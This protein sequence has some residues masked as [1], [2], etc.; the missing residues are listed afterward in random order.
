MDFELELIQK[1]E[2]NVS[3]ILRLLA[4]LIDA[5]EEEKAK[6]KQNIS[7]II[8][9]NPQLRSKKELIE[10]FI[11]GYLQDIS[12]ADL[13]DEAFEKYWDEQKDKAFTQI[14]EDEKLDERKIR[15]VIDTYIYDQRKPLNDD[16]AK[17]L[18]V[19]PKLLERKRVVPR[20]LEKV[21]AF[22]EKFY[23]GSGFGSDDSPYV[24]D[25][26]KIDNAMDDMLMA[27]EPKV[28]Y[29]KDRWSLNQHGIHP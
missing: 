18:T 6:Q 13:V 21:V 10:Q 2:I 3:Y 24:N 29:G 7:N 28:G 22:V 17:T 26:G 19:K 20:V 4:K 1:D 14:C 27:A 9:N 15:K 23:D 5:P 16:I 25:E 12:D 8:N 11:D